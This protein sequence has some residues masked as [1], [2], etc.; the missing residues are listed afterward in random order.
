MHSGHAINDAGVILA[1]SN[2]GL[3]MLRPGTRGTDA[4]VLGPIVTLPRSVELGQDLTLTVGFVDN[5]VTQTHKASVVWTDG[6]PSPAPTVREAAGTGQ[7]TLRHR[8]CAAGFQAVRLR[9]TD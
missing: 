9:V 5:S 6:C 8:F 2:A 4:P 7:V 1:N 3:V